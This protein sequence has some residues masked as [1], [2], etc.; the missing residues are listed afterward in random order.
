M[1]N[2]NL[3]YIFFDIFSLNDKNN[4]ANGIVKGGEVCKRYIEVFFLLR[5]K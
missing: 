5:I 4:V 1:C 2:Q 3:F